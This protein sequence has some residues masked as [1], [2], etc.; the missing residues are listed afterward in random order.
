NNA[1]ETYLMFDA[2]SITG[3]IDN[4]TLKVYGKVDLTTVPSV[5]I[6]VYSVA[7]TTWSESTITWNNKP[8][9]GAELS[10]AAVGN[11]AYSYINFDVTGY[12]KSEIAAGRK[13]VSFALKSLIAHDPRVFWNSKEFGSNP[14]QL[15]FI[16]QGGN[17]SP[18]V[19]ITS[20]ANGAV[21]TAPASVTIN[22]TAAD[23]DGNVTLV[24]FFNGSTKLGEDDTAPYTFTWSNVP[25]GDY[26]LTVRATDDSSATTTSSPVSITVGA[27]PPCTPVSASADDGNIPA[28]VLDNNLA[29]RWSASGDG[30]WIQFCLGAGPVPVTGVQ[31]A[32]YNG[33]VRASR[34]DIQVSS[35]G[36]TWT[37]VVTGLQ[38][39][40]ITNALET[41]NFAQVITKYIRI[42]GHGNTV[43]AWNS[44][45]EVKITT[46]PTPACDAVSAS[47]DDGNVPANV[48]DNDLATRWSASGDGQWIQF[49]LGSTSTVTGVQIA[50]YNGNVRTS[51]FDVLVSSNGINWTTVAANRV[52]SGT[53]TALETFTFTAVSAKYVRIV[54]HGN[55]V[56]LW[57]SYSEV[58]ILTSSALNNAAT[59]MNTISPDAADDPKLKLS[60]YPNPFRSGSTI[61]FNL[62]KSAHTQL[63]VYDISGR[64]V[65]ILVNSRLNAGNHRVVFTPQSNTA[66]MYIM[67]MTID[68]KVITKKLLKE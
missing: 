66:G 51:G 36:S 25:A 28:N 31:I 67:Q 19:S 9:S 60:T 3:N 27:E 61:T 10:T 54:G 26:T 37:N 7:N 48:L 13:K 58:R 40:G 47:G 42:L 16:V 45:T 65:A 35:N 1:R 52:S 32:F 14:P 56:N 46:A 8:A 38:S 34:F 21:F 39:S 6:G 50:F 24:E 55:S 59:E 43:N 41:F 44:Y 64:R 20:P 49:C 17:S 5:L 4:V 23:A 30:Q 18:S 22:A 2:T 63:S 62:E 11:T 53:S 57:N 15:A 29:T 33:N 12:V 68:G